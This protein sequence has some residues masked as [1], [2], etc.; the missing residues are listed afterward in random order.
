VDAISAIINIKLSSV[1]RRTSARAHPVGQSCD[2]WPISKFNG[3]FGMF[4]DD[5]RLACGRGIA[6]DPGRSVVICGDQRTG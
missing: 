6:S 4:R 5:R 2:P 3:T 1:G